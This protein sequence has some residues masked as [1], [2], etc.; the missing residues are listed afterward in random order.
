MTLKIFKNVFIF[1]FQIILIIYLNLLLTSESKVLEFSMI[2]NGSRSAVS[3]LRMINV[4]SGFSDTDT[5]VCYIIF[6]VFDKC[7]LKFTSSYILY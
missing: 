1:K 5:G 6:K 3:S 4:V 7:I 2:K